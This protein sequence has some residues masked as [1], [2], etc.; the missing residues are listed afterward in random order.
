[1]NETLSQCPTPAPP[2]S[3]C[4]ELVRVYRVRLNLTTG[5]YS[6]DIE[7]IVEAP[8]MLR[9][10]LSDPDAP[11]GL[12]VRFRLPG[13]YYLSNAAA[14]LRLLA[15]FGNNMRALEP[16]I[17]I[18]VGQAVMIEATNNTGGAVASWVDLVGVD[19]ETVE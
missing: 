11:T 15:S 8:F 6:P 13:N 9:G 1:M 10:I 5:E 17:Y 14:P 7:Q 3:P 19:R 18:P 16:E 2:T 4:V 12:L